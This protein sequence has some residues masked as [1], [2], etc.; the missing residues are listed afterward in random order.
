MTRPLS[1]ASYWLETGPRA[2]Q[3]VPQ[4]LVPVLRIC[5]ALTYEANC[6]PH[7]Q[8]TKKIHINHLKRWN[9]I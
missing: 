6:G 7:Q 2:F 4:G 9:E 1:T 5:G 8:D 3:V